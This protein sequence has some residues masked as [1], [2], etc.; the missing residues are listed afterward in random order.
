MRGGD[1]SETAMKSAG[2]TLYYRDSSRGSAQASEPAGGE[3]WGGTGDEGERKM[4]EVGN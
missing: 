4:T 1:E 2:T 3:G